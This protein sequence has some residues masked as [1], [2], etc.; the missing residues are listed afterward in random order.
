MI[1]ST[2]FRSSIVAVV[3]SLACASTALAQR[4]TT[5]ENPRAISTQGQ[6]SIKLVP[7]VA[8]V[9]V[10][11]EARAPKPGE[12]QRKAAEAMTAVQ[13]ALKTLGLPANAIK[14]QQYSLQPEMDYSG[15]TGKVK[16]YLARNTIEVRVDDIEKIGAVIDAAG[17][18]GAASVSGMRFDLKNREAVEREALAAAAKDGLERARAIATG[19]GQTIGV[20]LRVDDQRMYSAQPMARSYDAA[21]RGGMVAAAPAP[22]TPVE[23]GEIEIRAQMTVVVSIK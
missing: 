19:L 3:L 16:G 15:G 22:P 13:A 14:T 9:S 23:P 5:Q 18:S 7:D 21:G 17:A 1:R 8:W 11:A 6:A 20:I 10:A 2:L 12:A 4:D